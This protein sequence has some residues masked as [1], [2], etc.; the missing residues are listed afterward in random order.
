MIV[1]DKEFDEEKI[2]KKWYAV[3]E[4]V[5]VKDNNIVN[6][7]A[8]AEHASNLLRINERTISEGNSL[9]SENLLPFS[10][11]IMSRILELE[12][13]EVS[14]ERKDYKT[15]ITKAKR[16]PDDS[17]VS[18][19]DIYHEICES[20]FTT[21]KKLLDE[22]IQENGKAILNPYSLF[23]AVVVNENFF[24]YNIISRFVVI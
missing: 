14:F 2:I 22:K 16:Y 6:L 4:K 5:N 9:Y 17:F 8:Y 10:V 13:V 20:V 24:E 1:F 15:Y 11:R 18:I 21:I 19:G 12:N 7:A 3:L 23:D